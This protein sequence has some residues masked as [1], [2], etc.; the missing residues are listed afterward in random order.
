MNR[1]TSHPV[2]RCIVLC[3]SLTALRWAEA[4][5]VNVSAA[6]PAQSK[7]ESTNVSRVTSEPEGSPDALLDQ[8]KSFYR[9][10]KY[11]EAQQLTLT[12]LNLHPDSAQAMYLLAYIDEREKNPKE[13]LQWFTRAAA[14]DTPTAEDLRTVALDYA[15]LNDYSEAVHWLSRAVK[16]DPRNAE[17][18]YDLGR[19]YMMQDRF[20]AAEKALK[21]S[22]ELRPRSVRAENNLG[23]TLE[24]ENR[25]QEAADAYRTAIQWQSTSTTRSEQPLINLGTLLVAEQKASEAIPLLRLAVTIAARNTKAHE[26]L[27][28]ALEQT[29]D[30]EGALSEMQQAV[31]L[32]PNSARLHYELGQMDRRAGK[33][34][35][36]RKQLEMSGRLYGTSSTSPDR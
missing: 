11:P 25:E 21:T 30:S 14:V 8:A 17:A 32:E 18:W 15:L 16:F 31:Q 22:L 5:V 24:A 36:A 27:A 1:L 33:S 13:S 4:S 2:S 35:E 29:G 10:G 20:A 9:H 7:V 12:F 6:F 26:Q 34:A 28:R 3:L 19:T 23:V